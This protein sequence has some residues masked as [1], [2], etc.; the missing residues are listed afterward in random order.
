MRRVKKVNMLRTMIFSLLFSTQLWAAQCEVL[1]KVAA[2]KAYEL[3]LK[4]KKVNDIAII[5]R[6]CKSCFDKYPKPIVIDELEITDFQVKGFQEIKI[7]NDVIDL[8]YL[9]LEGDNLA[10]LVGCKTI[11]DS[12]YL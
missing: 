2:Q 12:S 6:F 7:N 9:F 5:D 8:A 1:P 3:L 4:H 10:K 11:T